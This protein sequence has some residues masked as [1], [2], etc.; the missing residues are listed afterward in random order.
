MPLDRDDAEE[1]VARLEKMMREAG[2]KPDTPGAPTP[3][4]VRGAKRSQAKVPVARPR[5]KPR[6][7]TKR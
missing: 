2:A 4:D 3:I 7:T 1:R 5:S 6:R